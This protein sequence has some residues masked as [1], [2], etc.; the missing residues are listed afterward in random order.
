MLGEAER[1]LLCKLR[2]SR[3][4]AAARTKQDPKPSESLR[5][6]GR[7]DTNQNHQNARILNWST[8]R[9]LTSLK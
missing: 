9:P 5:G 8:R 3:H 6:Y 1:Q 4:V 2:E 7:R